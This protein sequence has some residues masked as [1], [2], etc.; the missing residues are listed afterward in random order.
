MEEFNT[1]NTPGN[2]NINSKLF[3][4]LIALVVVVSIIW[5]YL[6]PDTGSNMGSKNDSGS[7]VSSKITTLALMPANQTLQKGS[8]FTVDIMLNT[9]G[10][11]IDGVDIFYLH[12]DPKI[13]QV[14][15]SDSASTGIQ[16]A[17]GGLMS[18]TLANIADNAKG[19][20]VLSQVTEASKKYNGEGKLGIVTFKAV[21]SGSSELKLD[22][23]PENTTDSNVSVAGKDI[24]AGVGNAN[25]TIQ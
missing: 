5:A 2:P 23:A 25:V 9:A 4:F 1:S 14:V 7:Q 24:L 10:R 11:D 17:A 16:I 21:G 12:F 3:V 22:Y 8:E 19:T 20:V 13:L 15:D 6:T 18:R